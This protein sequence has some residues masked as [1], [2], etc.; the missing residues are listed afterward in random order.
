MSTVQHQASTSDSSNPDFSTVNLSTRGS[1]TPDFST[2][3]S[4]NPDFSTMNLELK[5]PGLKL[6]V[7]Y[8]EVEVEVENSGVEMSTVQ[9]QASAPDSSNPDFSTV[10]LST[11]GSSTPDFST[12]NPSNPDVSTTNLE[13]KSPGLKLGVEYSEVENSGVEMSCNQPTAPAEDVGHDNPAH[14]TE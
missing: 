10:N 5:S 11:P 12:M 6:G 7:K 4:S 3:N 1:S 13:L 8:S 2:I 9:P 14:Q